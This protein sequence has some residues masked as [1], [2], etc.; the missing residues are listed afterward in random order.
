MAK[1]KYYLY[2]DESG[3]RDPSKEPITR[4]DN[5]DYFAFGGILISDSNR[6][7]VIEKYSEFCERWNIKDYPLHSTEIRGRRGNFKWLK[8]DELNEKFNK[9][10]IEF[11]CEIPV[12]GYAAV[13]SRTGYNS[14]YR[15]KYGGTPW[16]MCKTAF[17]IL[18]ERVSK[19]M[20]NKGHRF[21]IIIERCGKQEE[22]SIIEYFRSLRISGMPFDESNSATYGVSSTSLFKE[23][24]YG[25]P[26]FHLKKSPFLQ[27]AD[28]YLYPMVKGRYDEN[29]Y[30]YVT[31]KSNNK[32]VDS[33]LSDNE[34]SI[35][36]I[37]Y[38]CF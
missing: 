6:S 32:L 15:E 18:I 34:L 19:F 35:L 9:E 38:S 12:I 17:C 21:K 22:K 2:L 31:L 37:K 25:D 30:P 36:G 8:D 14:R 26:E 3:W 28:L 29:Y 11:L 16:L 33:C 13:I 7:I 27:I 4:N 1:E 24:P 5:M 23:I 10:L 20:K